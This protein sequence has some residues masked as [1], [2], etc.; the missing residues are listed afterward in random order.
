M[1]TVISSLIPTVRLH[2]VEPTARFWSD[3]ELT[4]LAILG[5]KDLWKAIADLKQ[6]HFITLNNSVTLQPNSNQ[7]SG[8]PS[9][10]HKIIMIEPVD[11]NTNGPNV[12]LLFKPLPYQDDIFQQARGVDPI[13]PRNDT[14]FYAVHAAGGPVGSPII[15][16]APQVTST[17]QCSL[18]YVP[19]LGPLDGT[20]T[21]PIPG[22]SD[23]AVIAYTVA[24]ARAKESENRAPDPGWLSLYGQEKSMLLEA[25]GVREYQ[26]L[27]TVRAIWQEYW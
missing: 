4:A 27:P 20:M 22:E 3:A 9:D 8:V 25:L 2:L 21:N 11:L 1:A 24:Y 10:V 7:L 26:E 16:V 18:V 23:Q 15:Q 12:G 14:I 17:V 5:I 6:N 13:D 19:V